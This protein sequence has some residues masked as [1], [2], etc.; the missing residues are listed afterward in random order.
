MVTDLTKFK[1]V[2]SFRSM[3]QTQ[4][5]WLTPQHS[6]SKIKQSPPG[7]NQLDIHNW[8][9]ELMVDNCGDNHVTAST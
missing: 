2:L 1:L 5:F 7:S 3:S 9:M 8:V 4:L 6:V